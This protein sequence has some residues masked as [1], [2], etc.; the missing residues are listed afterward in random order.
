MSDFPG[1]AGG[2][3][4]CSS[5]V[6]AVFGNYYLLNHANLMWIPTNNSLSNTLVVI[7]VSNPVLFGRVVIN[8]TTY[9]GKVITQNS[10]FVYGVPSMEVKHTGNF[11]VMS[12]GKEIR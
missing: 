6:N 2:S 12:C 8:G 10:E 9:L 5:Y 7:G 3:F 11:D 4:A 1:K